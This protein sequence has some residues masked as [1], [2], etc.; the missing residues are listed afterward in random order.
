[1]NPKSTFPLTIYDMDQATANELK[2]MLERSYKT[3]ATECIRKLRPFILKHNLRCK[4]VD[5]YIKV[6]K[7]IFQS[8]A[9]VFNINLATWTSSSPATRDKAQSESIDK[10]IGQL[11]IQL[12]CDMEILFL[13]HVAKF[14]P[15]AALIKKCGAKLAKFSASQKM[16]IHYITNDPKM[17]EP[18]D[19]LVADLNYPTFENKEQAYATVADLP[20]LKQ[21]LKSVVQYKDI[22]EKTPFSNEEASEEAPSEAL[23]KSYARELARLLTATY[24]KGGISISE[25]AEYMEQNFSFVK[26]WEI[27]TQKDACPFCKKQ[28]QKKYEKKDYPKNPIHLGCRCTVLTA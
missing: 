4:E 24:F 22:Y 6:F 21:R 27:S 25:K 11:P 13:G 1:M 26:G 23:K 10:A 7:P 12:H 17:K 8:K 3:T 28:A 19:K 14:D 2:E 9:N 18:F 20:D 5:D 16:G 15:K